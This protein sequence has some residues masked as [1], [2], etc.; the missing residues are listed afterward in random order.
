MTRWRW[1]G[2]VALLAV[3]VGFVV[4]PVVE[5]QN[6]VI[7]SDWPAFATGGR[8]IVENPS[9]LYDLDVQRR[10]QLEVTGGRTLV[11]LG[12]KGIL[13]FLAPAWV[14]FIAV[15]FALLGTNL[16]GRLWI[17]FELACL[18]FGLFL[19]VWPRPPT[20]WLP[21]FASVPTALLLLNAQVDGLVA[22]GVGAAIALRSKPY[23]AGAAL[24]LTLVKPQLVLT[25]GLALVLARMWR[26]IAG[27]TAAGVVMLISTLALNP[28]WVVD[29][30]RSAGGTVQPGAREVNVAHFGILFPTG[31]QTFAEACLALIAAIAVVWLAW[32]RREDLQSAAAIVV[33]GGVLAAPHALATD[34]VMVAVALALWGQAAWY[35]WLLLSTGAAV[36]ALLPAPMPAVVGV[37]VIGWVCLRVGR[38]IPAWRRGPAPASAG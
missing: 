23:L 37:L 36:A 35:D 34:L 9:H 25:I 19:A 13:P 38:V 24:G 32:R 2:S 27:W 22:L 3:A 10:T 33:A 14:A 15:P 12:I 6:D 21:A 28:R 30:L 8:L 17:L 5:G 4:Y 7:N 31:A 11:T 1:R 26:V 16:G 20:A 29:W 18:A